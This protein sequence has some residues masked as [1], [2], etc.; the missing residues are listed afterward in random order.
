M[1][2]VHKCK[3]D[4]TKPWNITHTYMYMKYSN[5]CVWKFELDYEREKIRTWRQSVWPLQNIT[6]RY[7]YT[8]IRHTHTHT[9]V[10]SIIRIL[11]NIKQHEHTHTHTITQLQQFLHD[12]RPSAIVAFEHSSVCFQRIWK[13]ISCRALCSLCLSCSSISD[14]GLAF[15]SSCSDCSWPDP[16]VGPPPWG[17]LFGIQTLPQSTGWGE[18]WLIWGAA[19]AEIATTV[20][21]SEGLD[22]WGERERE[23]ER[24]NVSDVDMCIV[25]IFN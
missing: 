8:N 22:L 17:S 9:Q 1:M 2:T 13:S 14:P 19:L 25:F 10:N 3:E 6:S 12:W 18:C 5:C 24:K 4:V 15:R 21:E 11:W 20:A 23:R 7:T 16:R